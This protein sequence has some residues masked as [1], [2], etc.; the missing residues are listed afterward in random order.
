MFYYL[1]NK[2]HI[3]IETSNKEPID[4]IELQMMQ[5]GS[6]IREI[7][8]QQEPNYEVWCAKHG[9][10]KVSL[11]HLERGG[12]A[13]LN[14]FLKVVKKLGVTLSDVSQNI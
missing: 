4:D 1:C 2:I 14:F 3:M 10:N 7:R 11:N 6:R 13:K 12:N 8:K 9:I 5:I